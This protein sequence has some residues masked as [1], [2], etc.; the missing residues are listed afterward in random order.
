MPKFFDLPGTGLED[1]VPAVVVVDPSTG[2]PVSF[3]G[4]GG[5]GGAVTIADGADAAQGA[6]SDAA[7]TAGAAGTLSAKLRSVSRDIGAVSTG[8]GAV[9]DAAVTNP[10]SSGSVIA[11][12]KGFLSMLTLTGSVTETAPASDTASSGVNGRL[13]RIAQNLTSLLNRFGGATLVSASGTITTGGTAQQ[14]AGSNAACRG[15]LIQNNSSGDL[16]FSTLA[17]AVQ[18]Q[19]SIRLPAGYFYESPL[20]GVGTGAISII[21]ATTGQAFTAREW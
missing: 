14:I 6:V 16:W 4:G 7:V 2:N 3:S 9:A 20:G 19:P 8:Q 10:A 1:A 5:G 11:L 18:S 12:L 15:F 21:G 17:T 13:Q